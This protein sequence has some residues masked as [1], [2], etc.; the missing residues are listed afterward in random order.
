MTRKGSPGEGGE[1]TV[2][3]GTMVDLSASPI[4]AI[5]AKVLPLTMRTQ[6]RRFLFDFA[7]HSSAAYPIPARPNKT[8]WT[9]KGRRRADMP[10]RRSA[11]Q[12]HALGNERITLPS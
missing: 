3:I 7:G 12:N 6:T 9:G 1:R 2:A 5:L 11:P 8:I 4:T 10:R